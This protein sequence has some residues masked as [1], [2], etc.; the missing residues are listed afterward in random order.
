M[1][2]ISKSKGAMISNMSPELQTGRY[3]FATVP[4]DLCSGDLLSEAISVF[5]E[6]EGVSLILP[7]EVAQASGFNVEDEMRCITLNVYSS[8]QGVGLTAAVSSA[9]GESDIPCNMVAAYHHDHV[10]VPA[11]KSE[12]AMRVLV[13]LQ[14]GAGS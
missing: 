11:E 9:L 12:L 7:T 4:E 14:D 1:N 10:F 2:S 3:V 5:Q 13:G 8:L 6:A